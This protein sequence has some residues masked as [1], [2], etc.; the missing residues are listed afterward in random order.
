MGVPMRYG[1]TPP[2]DRASWSAGRMSLNRGAGSESWGRRSG[3]KR[4]RGSGQ[5]GMEKDGTD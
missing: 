4:V 1:Q 5:V 3:K 2:A